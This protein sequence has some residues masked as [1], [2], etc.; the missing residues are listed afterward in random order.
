[1]RQIIDRGRGP[2]IAGTRVTVYDILDYL[3]LGWQHTAIAGFFRLSSD[4]VQAAI[5]FIEEHQEEV[6]ADYRKILE[7]SA[8]GNPPEVQTRL[9]A[10][11]A[12]YQVLWAD[13][14]R[15][16]SE[17]EANGESHPG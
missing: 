15:A 7:R 17:A 4:Q 12:K 9:D 3:E 16:T 1:M 10:I 2:E 11:H 8:R 14:L 6:T 13:R 5:Q